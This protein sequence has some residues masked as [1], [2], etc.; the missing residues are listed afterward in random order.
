[1]LTKEDLKLI[2]QLLDEKFGKQDKRIDKKFD[3]FAILVNNAFQEQKEWT[4]EWAEEYV[5]KEFHNH[6]IL[7]EEEFHKLKLWGEASFVMRNEFNRRFDNLENRVE[8]IEQDVK[9]MKKDIITIKK[10][11]EEVKNRLAKLEKKDN[12]VEKLEKRVIL[13]ERQLE[14]CK[15]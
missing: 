15:K 7:M 14:L 1:M 11:V 6:N 8:K 5:A 4:K 12:E 10:D 9:F 3:D 2:G 13:I